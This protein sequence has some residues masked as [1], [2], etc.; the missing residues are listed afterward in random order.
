MFKHSKTT[1]WRK[2]FQCFSFNGFR[3][4]LVV[5]G[6]RKKCLRRLGYPRFEGCL[7]I[8]AS[9]NGG[10]CSKPQISTQIGPL[11]NQSNRKKAKNQKVK[12][13]NKL[14]AIISVNMP[15]LRPW[16]YLVQPRLK[17]KIYVKWLGQASRQKRV[18]KLGKS[19]VGIYPEIHPDKRKSCKGSKK[20]TKGMSINISRRRTKMFTKTRTGKSTS[21]FRE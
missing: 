16:F 21:T 5:Q 15:K 7:H 6:L 8:P 14:L 20:S 10:N 2:F 3:S 17:L 11:K 12:A 19:C 4:G 18:P 13:I 9:R 1:K